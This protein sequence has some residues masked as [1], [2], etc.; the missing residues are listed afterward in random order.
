M[1]AATWIPVVVL[2]LIHASKPGF[3][4]GLCLLDPFLIHCQPFFGSV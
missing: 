4:G 3:A 2:E 1:V